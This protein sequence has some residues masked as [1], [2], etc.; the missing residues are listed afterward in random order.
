[1]DPA[2]NAGNQEFE[3]DIWYARLERL[4][5]ERAASSQDLNDLEKAAA[6][7]KMFADARKTR[8]DLQYSSSHIRLEE[9]KSWAFLAIPV[10]L[11]VALFVF[12]PGPDQQARAMRE[13]NGESQWHEVERNFISQLNTAPPTGRPDVLLLTTPLQ[14]FLNDPRHGKE[15]ADLG[16]LA[17]SH[18]AS[19]DAFQDYF[20]SR[21]IRI[22]QQNLVAVTTLDRTLYTNFNELDDTVTA[23]AAAGAAPRVTLSREQ[24]QRARD[25]VLLELTFL[26]GRLGAYFRNNFR[27]APL[28]ADLRR[29]YLK[30]VDLSNVDFGRS[31]IDNCE[32]EGVSLTGADLSAIQDYDNSQWIDANWWD[33]K[34][35]S[36]PLLSYLIANQYPYHPP[37]T[38]YANAPRSRDAYAD[39]VSALC[40][41]AGLGC[42]ADRFPYGTPPAKPVAPNVR[43]PQTAAQ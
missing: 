22:S 25:A 2:N 9:A 42:I 43:Q 5:T 40:N 14:P 21:N 29:L 7:A 15:A 1:M 38:D 39:K 27:D 18:L 32:W 3:A 4:A 37:V 8:S 23:E 13:A 10:L 34:R 19:S 36:K 24:T 30:N 31:S 11:L 6:A 12:V 16:L 17:L 26:S 33:A 28:N 20:V 41:A 35:I